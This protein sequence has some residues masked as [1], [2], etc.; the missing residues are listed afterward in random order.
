MA[1]TVL[2]GFGVNDGRGPMIEVR[3]DNET[4]GLISLVSLDDDGS[5]TGR[6]TFL[7]GMAPMI[8]RA[9]TGLTP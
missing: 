2:E 5:E 9:L 3:E 1:E 6:V 8:G 7:R 4:R